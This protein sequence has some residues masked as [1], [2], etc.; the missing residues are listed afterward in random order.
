MN[1]GHPICPKCGSTN[2]GFC[3]SRPYQPYT[4]R[5]CVRNFS[6]K[7][8]SLLTQTKIPYS[9]WVLGIFIASSNLRGLAGMK[10]YRDIEMKKQK[11]V[12]LLSHKIRK[13]WEYDPNVVFE[14][15][16]EV[17]EM[18]PDGI[19][20][21]YSKKKRAMRLEYLFAQ[22]K[23]PQGNPEDGTMIM[24]MYDRATKTT[25]TKVLWGYKDKKE[26]YEM[27]RKW[28]LKH[29]AENAVVITDGELAYAPLNRMGRRHRYISHTDDQYSRDEMIDGEIVD[30]T[31]N[32]IETFWQ[33]VRRSYHGTFYKMSIKH[34][35]RYL[36]EVSGRRNVR[37]MDTIEIME[38]IADRLFGRKLTYKQLTADNGLPSYANDGREMKARWEAKKKGLEEY[39]DDSI[40][41]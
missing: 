2:I 30:I 22:G 26:L 36:D 3:K 37:E 17:D 40:P 4:C 33:M 6:F 9:T 13:V 35:Q 11:R 18:F 16:V 27:M 39:L 12:W 41:Y 32:R 20:K 29:T 24:G 14:G 31:T 19:V 28:V 38:W 8:G 7:T 23:S 5:D 21:Y 34:M 1:N 25:I 10:M 15:P